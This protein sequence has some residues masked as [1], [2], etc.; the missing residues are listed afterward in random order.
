MVSAPFNDFVEYSLVDL[1]KPLAK[2]QKHG[3]CCTDIGDRDRFSKGLLANIFQHVLD[4]D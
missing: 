1:Q 4:E 3:G 2:R